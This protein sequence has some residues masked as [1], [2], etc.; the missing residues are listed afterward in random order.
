[1]SDLGSQGIM[2]LARAANPE[3]LYASCY[4]AKVV[5]QDGDRIDV[6]PDDSRVPPMAGVPLTVGIPGAKVSV[7]AGARV[8]V[9]WSG[10]DPRFPYVHGW[11]QSEK[12]VKLVLSAARVELATAGASNGIPQG[13]ELRSLIGHILDQCAAISNSGGPTANAAAFTALK[14]ELDTLLSLNVFTP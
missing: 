1:M 11:D 12:V 8:L 5:K 4:W 13:N 2:R 6:Q 14:L 10:G 3:T 7:S 9:G